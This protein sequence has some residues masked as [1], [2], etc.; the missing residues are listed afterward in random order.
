MNI[1][2]ILIAL[3]PL[4]LLMFMGLFV[5]SFMCPWA[6][7]EYTIKTKFLNRLLVPFIV[8]V[9]IMVLVLAVTIAGLTLEQKGHVKTV[10]SEYA[11]VVMGKH[12]ETHKYKHMISTD[13]TVLPTTP[14]TA[15]RHDYYVTVV[16]PDGQEVEAVTN[17]KVYDH[18]EKGLAVII[19]KAQAGDDIKYSARLDDTN[20][21]H[22]CD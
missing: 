8:A 13:E 9:P 2:T 21:K 20:A 7:L 12:V 11:A 16:L 15:K 1:Y 5:W 3:I 4:I 19:D 14:I 10:H 22:D 6:D 17:K 18:V